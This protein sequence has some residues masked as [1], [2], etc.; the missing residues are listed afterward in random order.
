MWRIAFHAAWVTQHVPPE[1]KAAAIITGVGQVNYFD[2][3]VS[4]VGMNH[5]NKSLGAS[6]FTQILV[7]VAGIIID[8]AYTRFAVAAPH[9]QLAR[10]EPRRSAVR[11]LD[12]L[13]VA[14]PSGL[15]SQDRQQLGFVGLHPV[16]QVWRH[17]RPGRVPQPVAMGF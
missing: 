11:T 14:R 9:R 6:P 8:W 10:D 1:L 3:I 13:Q 5:A 15:R 12:W 7:C 2:V 4:M 17:R 16:G